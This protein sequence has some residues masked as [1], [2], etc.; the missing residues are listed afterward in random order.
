M[1]IVTTK[2]KNRFSKE[3]L[4][5]YFNPSRTPNS[6]NQ[7]VL[8]NTEY[9]KVG[10]QWKLKD[11][12]Y[13]LASDE[14]Y[15]NVLEKDSLR[16]FRSLG[17]YEKNVKRYTSRGYIPVENISINPD[18]TFKHVREFIEPSEWKR[19]YQW[20]KTQYPMLKKR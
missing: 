10:S 12:Y 16:F 18:R 13:E 11:A 20:Y 4:G 15:A 2:S 19:D 3:N 9:I 8:L 1:I 5:F 7:W 17:G 14:M 6:R